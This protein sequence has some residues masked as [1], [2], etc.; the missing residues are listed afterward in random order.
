MKHILHMH[1]MD[2]LMVLLFHQYLL[3]MNEQ[4]NYMFVMLDYRKMMEMMMMMYNQDYA[5]DLIEFVQMDVDEDD[6][7]HL[8]MAGENKVVENQLHLNLMKQELMMMIDYWFDWELWNHSH[9]YLIDPMEKKTTYISF[10]KIRICWFHKI[11][12]INSKDK[13]QN[14]YQ[15]K[16]IYMYV[17][18]MSYLLIRTYISYIC[19]Q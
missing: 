16:Y 4:V 13:C 3:Q 18:K 17:Y 5:N 1:H 15:K 14:I 9:N 2:D 10:L 8:E 7:I 19:V 11:T 12:L 6:E